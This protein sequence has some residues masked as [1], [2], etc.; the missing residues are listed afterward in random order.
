LLSVFLQGQLS[1]GR[2]VAIKDYTIVKGR[3]YLPDFQRMHQHENIVSILGYCTYT[4]VEN[5]L[6][7]REARDH[8]LVVEEYMP[9]GSLCEILTGKFQCNTE[10]EFTANLNSSKLR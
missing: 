2:L 7:M 5:M 4:Q 3:K 1:D 8:I 9:N 10:L 6:D